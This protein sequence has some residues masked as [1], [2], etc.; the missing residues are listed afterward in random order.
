VG[1]L[2]Q[3][4]KAWFTNFGGWVDACAPAIDIVSTFFLKPPNV[5]L[6]EPPFTGW[7]RWSG[8]SFAAPKVAAV[9][10][11]EMYVTGSDPRTCWKRL[12]DYRRYRFPDLGTVFNV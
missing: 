7:A 11:Q 6:N 8:T 10:A 9:I 5:K 12:S 4:D 1:G 2:G 3:A